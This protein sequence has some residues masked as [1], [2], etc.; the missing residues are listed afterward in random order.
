MV[1]ASPKKSN[2]GSDTAGAASKRKERK[3]NSGEGESFDLG[4]GSG[5]AE[6]IRWPPPRGGRDDLAGERIRARG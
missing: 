3:P 2:R 5:G 1:G 6:R 4:P